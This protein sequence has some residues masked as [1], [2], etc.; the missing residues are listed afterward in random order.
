MSKTE[1]VS[2]FNKQFAEYLKLM[3]MLFPDDTDIK[4]TETSL[5]ALRKVNPRII[6]Q[7][8]YKYITLKYREQIYADNLDYFVTKNYADDLNDTDNAKFI[9]RKIEVLRAPISKLNSENK[10][11]TLVFLKNLTNLS[12]IYCKN[13]KTVSLS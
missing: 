11:K 5:L 12:D 4:S 10:E 1:I 2:V 6:I 7:I 8:W 3:T 13:N 9:L